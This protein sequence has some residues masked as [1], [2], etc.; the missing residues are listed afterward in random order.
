MGFVVRAADEEEARWLAHQ[1]AGDEN[2]SIE[3]VS[4]WLDEAY[5]VCRPVDPDGSGE[6]V[7]VN[8]RHAPR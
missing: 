1:A 8:F 7:L 4:P 5:S 2:G 3:G 6:V